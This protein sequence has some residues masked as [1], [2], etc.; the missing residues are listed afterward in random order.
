[1]IQQLE[2]RKKDPSLTLRVKLI[3]ASENKLAHYL[4]ED[5]A[6]NRTRLVIYRRFFG[7]ARQIWMFDMGL[8]FA[9][10]D[11]EAISE[12]EYDDLML[13]QEVH[14]M[15]DAEIVQIS[16]DDEVLR[17]E[18]VENVMEEGEEDIEVEPEEEEVNVAALGV[19]QVGFGN[20]S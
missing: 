7:G 1:M 13:E 18:A 15:L 6:R 19:G 3:S 5:G 12:D 9:E 11:F 10:G 17:D 14:E 2:Q 8:G 16:D 20:R 4:A